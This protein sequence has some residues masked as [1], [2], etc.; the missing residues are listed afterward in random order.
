MAAQRTVNRPTAFGIA[1]VVFVVA[2][3][4]LAGCTS[5]GSSPAGQPTSRQSGGTSGTAPAP[6]PHPTEVSPSGDIPDNQAYVAFTAADGSY[7]MSVPEGWARSSSGTSTTFTDKLN[8]IAT[9][10]SAATS[11]PTVESVKKNEVAHLSSTQSKF[12]L[13]DV[14]A[15]AR[16]GG[17]GIL[18]R[19]QSDSPVNSVTGSVVRDEV[20][21]YL[22]WKGGKQVTVTLTSP[23]GSDN[24]DP[25]AKVTGSFAWLTK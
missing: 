8:V 24:V 12:A 1:G 25:W 2:G 4:A 3:L 7:T 22:F 17:S 23:K 10:S 5:T 18:I 13:T 6:S 15:F 21:Q 16:A 9:D 14:T 20:E 19:F 11:A